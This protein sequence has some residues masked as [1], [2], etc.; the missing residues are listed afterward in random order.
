MVVDSSCFSEINSWLI[1]NSA[2]VFFSSRQ[3]TRGSDSQESSSS[4]MRCDSTL[5]HH[6]RDEEDRR[7][8]APNYNKASTAFHS[9]STVQLRSL[10]SLTRKSLPSHKFRADLAVAVMTISSV[11][12]TSLQL[13]VLHADQRTPR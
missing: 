11:G 4:S 12:G 5:C 7:G 1:S 13:F 10:L 3:F 8:V 6:I 2:V 9:S